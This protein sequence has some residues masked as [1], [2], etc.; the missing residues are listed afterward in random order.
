MRYL[1]NRAGDQLSYYI[2][3]V[4]VVENL[5]YV[6][7]DFIKTTLSS[8]HQHTSRAIYYTNFI[9]PRKSVTVHS[10][11]LF[12][13]KKKA[14]VKNVSI[15]IDCQQGS[16]ADVYERK[17]DDEIKDGDIDLRGRV[18]MPGFVDSHAHIFLHPY[19]SGSVHMLSI[20]FT[21]FHAC[22]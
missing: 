3:Y 21:T 7:R 10:S 18:V 13:P 5:R 16:I 9:M 12:D 11:L 17:S 20:T 4:C 19:R 8:F 14:F 1:S 15:T 2:L 6:A 22:C